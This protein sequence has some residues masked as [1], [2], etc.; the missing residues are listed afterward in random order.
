MEIKISQNIQANTLGA[1][2]E[3]AVASGQGTGASGVAVLSGASVSVKG[4]TDFEKLLAELQ[5][6]RDE[7]KERLFRG[8]FSAAIA[9][10]ASRQEG[11]TQA[12]QEAIAVV[13]EK[14]SALE[15]AAATVRAATEGLDVASAVLQTE[16]EKLE[17]MIEAQKKTPEER[18]AEIE[19]EERV[20]EE[21]EVARETKA[22]VAEEVETEGEVEEKESAE[23]QAQRAKVAALQG[24]VAAKTAAL[25]E[26][27]SAEAA[28]TVE[29][30]NATAS[31][32]GTAHAVVA[33]AVRLAG[34]VV[35]ATAAEQTD[36][37][38]E[39]GEKADAIVEALADYADKLE[40]MRDEELAERIAKT[41]DDIVFLATAQT[42][43][44][45]GD[46]PGYEQK[47]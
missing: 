19:T 25:S 32:D 5:L 13:G 31:L 27:K 8:Q 30:K 12:Q 47:V 3:A 39:V 46:L 6:E 10:L 4:T 23:I 42:L 22:E 36:E 45:P 1:D 2:T 28:A 38:K 15:Q 35:A 7:Q 20:A 29:L 33:D 21:K 16:I 26:A 37:S 18:L 40:E 17:Q 43:L 24:D 41:A 9:I 44:K 11:L 14:S 34:K